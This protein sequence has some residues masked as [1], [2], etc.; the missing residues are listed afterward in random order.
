M[1]KKMLYNDIDFIE[2]L[3]QL[4]VQPEE[5]Q[6]YIPQESIDEMKKGRDKARKIDNHFRHLYEK[7]LIAQYQEV[8]NE[9]FTRNNEGFTFTPK[10]EA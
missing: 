2:V 7:V 4:E 3:K 6:I 1:E 10:K 8:L 9:M 5:P